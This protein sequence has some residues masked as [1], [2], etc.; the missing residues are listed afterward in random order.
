MSDDVRVK[1]ESSKSL[2]PTVL[3]TMSFELLE[4]SVALFIRLLSAPLIKSN[5]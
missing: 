5:T 4:E 3:L 2:V 1:L